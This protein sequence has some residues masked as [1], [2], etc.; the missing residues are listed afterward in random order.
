[1]NTK[2]HKLILIFTF[3]FL[4]G[5]SP[6]YADNLQ[7]GVAAY[8]RQDYKE[9]AKWYRLSA[10][11]GTAE[12]QFNLGLIYANGRGVPQDH[13]EAVKWFRLSGEQ[14]FAEAQFNLGLMYAKGRGVPQDHKEAVK[15]YRLSTKQGT[16]EAQYNLGL[17]Y[18]KGRG[19][20]QD[21]VLTHMWFNIAGSNGMKDAIKNRA[22]VEKRMTQ[23]QIEKAQEMARNWKPTT[24]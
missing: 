7:D 8:Q 16:A 5:S 12:A 10:E 6:V 23:Q 9:A 21:Y 15:W 2:S 11:Q 14:G 18:A 19:V 3:L 24:N 17:M 1:M 20:P 22:I 4:I 13:K